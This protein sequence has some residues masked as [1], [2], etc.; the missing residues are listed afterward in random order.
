[1]S[2]N[3]TSFSKKIYP[4][5]HYTV[6]NFFNES[7]LNLLLD[8]ISLLPFKQSKDEH[9]DEYNV[10]Y[11]AST[12][13]VVLDRFLQKDNIEF[14][15]NL[16]NRLKN[17]NKLLRVSIWKDYNGFNLPMHTDSHFKLFTMQIYLPRNNEQGYGTSFY[18]QNGV[19]IK[20]TNYKLN[21]GYFFFP[22]YQQIKTN[23]SFIENIT[24]ERC[25][26][27]Y[28]I[29][30]RDYYTKKSKDNTNIK[31]VDGIEF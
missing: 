11:N 7:Q 2:I 9:R 29:F 24:T 20:K 21:D 31:F 19:F 8:Q 1:M 4:W 13:D 18:D 3:Q 25:S 17:T 22:N 23:H 10:K 14:I 5:V 15:T 12:L 16:D 28:N 27:I 6:H 30:D 26:I